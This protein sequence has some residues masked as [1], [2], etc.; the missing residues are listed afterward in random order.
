[1]EYNSIRMSVNRKKDDYDVNYVDKGIENDENDYELN[2]FK[3]G[4]RNVNG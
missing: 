1:M 4:Y 3:Y 2:E